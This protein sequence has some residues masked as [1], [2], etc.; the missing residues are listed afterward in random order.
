MPLRISF[1]GLI[2]AL[3]VYVCRGQA[4]VSDT[5]YDYSDVAAQITAGCNTKYDKAKAIYRWLCANISYDT[6]YSIYTAD[7]CWD[8]Q[9][10]VC[11][12]YC[13]LFY[14]LAEP[15]GI[16]VFIIS[17]D[18]KE[19]MGEETGH[20]WIF[21]VTEGEGTGILVDPTWGAGAVDGNTFIRSDNNMSWFHVDP[22]WMIFSHYPDDEMFQLIDRPITRQQFLSLPDIRPI[23]GQYGYD[24]RQMLMDCLSDRI[25]MP[26]L[27][28]NAADKVI[29]KN[30][31]FENTLR[32][33]QEYCFSFGKLD[34][35]D[36]VLVNENIYDE[37]SVDYSTGIYSMCFVPS[38]AGDLT[39]SIK[40]G[41]GS[42]WSF[43][44]YEV[45][46]PTAYD[47]ARLQEAD[48]LAMPEIAH[49][50]NADIR[51]M[52]SLGIDGRKLLSQVRSG[53]VK[54]L[55]VFYDF[56][57]DCDM[58]DIPFNE[59]LYR[60][61]EYTFTLRPHTDAQ[62]AIINEGRW[63]RD[64][65]KDP[66]SGTITITVSPENEGLLILAVQSGDSDRYEYCLQYTVR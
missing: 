28:D 22:Y 61:R 54:S 40:K 51:R 36:I 7:E 42:Y 23:W 3:S 56:N 24:A 34:E 6:S 44:Q 1:I 5:R 13:E 45:A 20:A 38:V 59:V 57:N 26:Q 35:C 62:W 15:L 30:I 55:P 49:L 46:Q 17:G 39:L 14:R 41:D 18:T 2:I 33:G 50:R 10:G 48:P 64:W 58:T 29:L 66:I 31:P 16:K 32:I 53:E 43:L 25:S 12:A 27:N 65:V 4:A 63:L 11:Q 52:K 21:V 9:R 8:N 37:W 47:L 19:T 60:G